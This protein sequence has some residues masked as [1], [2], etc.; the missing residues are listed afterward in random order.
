MKTFIFLLKKLF[1][2]IT[3]SLILISCGGV[4]EETSSTNSEKKSFSVADVLTMVAHEN[5]ITRTLYT[6]A[7]VGGGKKQGFK[8]D[9]DWQDEKVEAGPLPALFLRG[10]A[11]DIR[12]GDVPLGLYLSSDFPINASNQLEGKQAD[13]Y[14][15]IKENRKPKHFFDEDTKLYTAMFADVAGAPACVSCH[16]K[17]PK[18][19]KTDWKL[20]DVMGTTTWQYPA[21]SLSYTE[22]MS[23]LKAYRDGTTA[24][25]NDYLEEIKNFKES[26]KPEVGKKWPSNGKYL[27][28]PEVFIDSVRKLSAYITMSSLMK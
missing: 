19:T 27:P 18:T 5:D 4:P 11:N 1:S 21:D 7:I 26:E 24:V 13:L 6:K 23:V 10:I 9:E 16:N 12:K 14:K 2:F 28:A 20:G 3:L 22:A 17:H 25:Y 15:D 8:F